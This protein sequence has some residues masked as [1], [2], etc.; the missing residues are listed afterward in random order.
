MTAL[1][2]F[3][4]SWVMWMLGRQHW[5]QGISQAVLSAALFGVAY[6]FFALQSMLATVELQVASKTFISAAMAAFTVALQRFR[7]STD[8]T[9][10]S[11]TVFAPLLGSLAL[12]VMYVPQDL[13]TFNRL[14]TLITVLQTA[15]TLIVLLHMRFHTPGVGWTLVT[16]AACVQIV[17]ILPLAF[18]SHRPS[19]GFGSEAPVGALL[20]MWSVCLMLFLKLM[21]TSTGFLIMLRDRQVAL[22]RHRAQIDPL[23]QLPNRAALVSDLT[24][25]LDAAASA[26]KPL[27]V[28]ML[29]IDHFKGFNDQHGHLAGDQ[30]LR[31][32]AQILQRQTRGNDFVARYGGEEF[33]I[34][35]PD[36]NA[37]K[38]LAMAQRVC[39]AI[40]TTQLTLASGAKLKITVSA[41]VH[42]GVPHTGASWESFV[43]AADA[44]MY[45]AK[46]SGRDRV[47]ISTSPPGNRRGMVAA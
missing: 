32:V 34:V 1:A 47:V 22:E 2:A 26:G 19:P 36:T 46:H 37:Q 42:V 14:Q 45:D 6:L 27:S 31:L 28:M 23:T 24:R 41:G 4:V 30:V 33:I 38:A 10:D 40:R 8:V 7:Q 21:V 17:S 5:R 13:G 16:G 29:D 39:R 44:A 3:T 18:S 9:R 25:A 20:A 12:A 15:Y 43:A 11:I 35:L